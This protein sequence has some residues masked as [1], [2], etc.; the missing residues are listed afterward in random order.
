MNLKTCDGSTALLEFN[1]DFDIYEKSKIFCKYVFAKTLSISNFKI[2]R[3]S[4]IED[5]PIWK[6]VLWSNNC[7]DEIMFKYIQLAI[8]FLDNN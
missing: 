5:K 8:H 2:L 7:L 3:K 6:N 1:I 4:K